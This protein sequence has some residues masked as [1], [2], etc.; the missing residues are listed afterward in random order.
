MELREMLEKRDF[1]NLLNVILNME[2]PGVMDELLEQFNDLSEYHKIFIINTG[3]MGYSQIW[4]NEFYDD[5][6]IIFEQAGVKNE[7]D[8]SLR[9]SN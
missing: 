8:G 1:K 9:S 5:L 7:W 3:L 2:T 6:E 4:M